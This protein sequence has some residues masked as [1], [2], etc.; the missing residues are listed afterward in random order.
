[1]HCR[2]H[3]SHNGNHKPNHKPDQIMKYATNQNVR[4]GIV[5]ALSNG[6][7]NH[8][9]FIETSEGEMHVAQLGRLVFAGTLCNV[10]MLIDWDTVT[11]VYG[12]DD[13]VVA[14]IEENGIETI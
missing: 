14:L 9:G 10:G 3:G 13:P 4:R 5:R 2:E 8:L 6:K 1:M 7:V 12:G 11:E